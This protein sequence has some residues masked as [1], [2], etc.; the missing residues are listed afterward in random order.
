MVTGRKDDQGKL[1]WSL[2]PWD[3]V[4]DVVK[5]LEAGAKKYGDDNW[6][7]VEGG[8]TRYFDALLRHLM[9]WREGERLDVE[10]GLPHLA[11]A[12]CC[13]LFLLWFDRFSGYDDLPD[14]LLDTVP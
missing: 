4:K 12:G 3:S 13:V 10:T 14:I 8:R 2:L 1:R 7:M 6:K 9:A 11:H 5:V